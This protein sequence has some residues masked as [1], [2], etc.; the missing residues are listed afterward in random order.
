MTMPTT[1]LVVTGLGAVSAVGLSPDEV[2]ASVRSG[3]ALF[4]ETAILD[5]QFEPVVL[6]EIPDDALPPLADDLADAGLTSR[7]ARM[8][9]LAALALA[10]ALNAL[11]KGAAPPPLVLALPEAETPRPL[12]GDRFLDA[13][14][15]QVPGFD[16]GKSHASLRGRAGGLV[17]L[18]FASELL[19]GAA[20]FVVAGGIDTFRDPYILGTLDLEQRL[21][22]QANLDGFVPGEAAAFLLLATAATAASTGAPKLASIPGI[23]G[24]REP[25]H[26]KSEQPYRGDG[27]AQTFASLLGNGASRGPVR[28]VY[29]SMNGE[30]HWAKEW[31]VALLRNRAAFDE[32]H[33]MH[34][35]ADCHG[36]TGAAAGPLMIALATLGLKDGYR[37]SPC[38]VY[39]SSD[40]DERAAA[41]VTAV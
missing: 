28:D 24:A 9:R 32:E 15:V 11:P 13:L 22:S 10:Q 16:R 18:G 34:H 4:S 1:D 8:V 6:A 36:D 33:G 21:K 38:L 26:L 3:T 17:A 25:G 31:G 39:A 27:L 5:R 14:A 35:P 30:S 7:E 37:R 41:L 23:G 40:R 29:S 20:P 19:R 12:D 2:A